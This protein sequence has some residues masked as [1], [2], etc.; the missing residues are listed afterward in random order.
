M[1]AAAAVTFCLLAIRA[2]AQTGFPFTIDP[3]M[4]KGPAKAPVTIVEF[5]DYQ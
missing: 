5:S 1:L 4:T 2:S 3:A